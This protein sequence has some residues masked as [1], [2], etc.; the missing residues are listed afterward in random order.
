MDMT[1]CL[2]LTVFI[3]MFIGIAGMIVNKGETVSYDPTQDY[4]RV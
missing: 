1:D 2:V 4:Y 3:L